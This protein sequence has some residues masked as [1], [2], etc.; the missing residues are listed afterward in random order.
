MILAG[1]VIPASNIETEN[2]FCAPYN[3][4]QD[5]FV[6]GLSTDGNSPAV[7]YYCSWNMDD[8][9]Y[10]NVFYPHFSAEADTYI[11]NYTGSDPFQLVISLGL[12]PVNTG[13]N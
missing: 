6:V 3:N 4:G 12:Q 1:M 13:V 9:Q 11:G 10:N 5:A 7:S 8:D 2:A